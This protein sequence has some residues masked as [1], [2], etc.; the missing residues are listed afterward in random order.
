LVTGFIGLLQLMTTGNYNSFTNSHTLQFTVART[1]SSVSSVGIATQQLPTVGTPTSLSEGICH[2]NLKLR[3][4]CLPADSLS[5]CPAGPLYSLGVDPTENTA[6]NSSC[7]AC[8]FVSVEACLPRCCLAVATSVRPS[9]LAFSCYVNN[10][11][12]SP[13]GLDSRVCP[14]AKY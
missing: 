7:I 8:L 6:S 12:G 1:K 10:K 2:N 14:Y 13:T 5:S 4:V 11:Y 3:L 9:I